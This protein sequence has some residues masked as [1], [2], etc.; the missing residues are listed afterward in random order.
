MGLRH[1]GYCLLCCG[2][3]MA[4]LFVLGV[5]NL[6]WIALLATFVLVEKLAS[7]GPW[8]TRA[9]GVLLVGWG[10]WMA[11]WSFLH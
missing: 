2:A 3:L 7:S 5:M 10:V 4:L 11:G 6:A 8:L 9:S 1:G